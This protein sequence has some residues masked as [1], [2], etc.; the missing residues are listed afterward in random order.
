M[1]SL[2]FLNLSSYGQLTVFESAFNFHEPSAYAGVF[3]IVAPGW[4]IN[5]TNNIS[6]PTLANS[7]VN[8]FMV[9]SFLQEGAFYVLF[10]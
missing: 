6:L 10:D 1:D 9:L 5:G 3:F 2:Q 7:T 4:S 8:R